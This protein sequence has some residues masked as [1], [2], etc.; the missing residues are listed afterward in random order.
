MISHSWILLRGSSGEIRRWTSRSCEDGG[1]LCEKCESRDRI[2]PSK[3]VTPNLFEFGPGHALLLDF[4]RMS[5]TTDYPSRILSLHPISC[6][7][8]RPVAPT[9]APTRASEYLPSHGLT[10]VPL[11]QATHSSGIYSVQRCYH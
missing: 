11:T 10:D 8:N 1:V 3:C 9:V 4:V 6:A 5:V 2:C 7:G